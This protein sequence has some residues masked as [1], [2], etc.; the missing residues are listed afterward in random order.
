MPCAGAELGGVQ[1]RRQPSLD[2][3]L[4]DEARLVDV[5]R[6]AIA[7]HVDPPRVFAALVQHVAGDEP[8][9][10]VAVVLIFARNHVRSK[11]CRL[12]GDLRAQLSAT[13]L[14]RRWSGRSRSWS[15]RWSRRPGA[16]RSRVGS[17][18]RPARRPRRRGWPR[19]W[20]RCRH[21]RR[22]GRS[23]GRRTRPPCH[24]RRS[25]GRGCRRTPA[26]RSRLRSRP[27]DPLGAHRLSGRATRSGR[28]RSP[29]RHR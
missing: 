3:G 12:V 11:E 17:G 5:E 18:W 24:R 9:V 22:A 15:R 7:E 29:A 6:A 21:R 10:G 20:W 1:A 8:D 16:V 14:R 13:A 2:A 19:R 27:V 26:A 25:G 28:R 23:F 4:Q